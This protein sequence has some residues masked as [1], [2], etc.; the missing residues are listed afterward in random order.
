MC[1]SDLT[2]IPVEKWAEDGI[3][4]RRIRIYPSRQQRKIL[5]EWIHTTRYVYNRCVH[6]L[7][8]VK[9]SKWDHSYLKSLFITHKS[10][11]GQINQNL[12]EWEL[13]T[14][15]HVRDG[16]VR[17]LLKGYTNAV[18]RCKKGSIARFN[19]RYRKRNKN[20]AIVIPKNSVR[21]ENGK[22]RMFPRSLPELIRTSRDKSVQNLVIDHDC[23]LQYK[24]GKWYLAVPIKVKYSPETGLKKGVASLDPGVRTF[25]TIYNEEEVTQ[26]CHNRELLRRIQCK[27]DKFRSLRA[28]KVIGSSHYKR[29]TRRLYERLYNLTDELHYKTISHLCENYRLILI[30]IFESQE[31]GMR[32]KNRYMNREMFQLQH[33]K[34]RQRLSERCGVEKYTSM[35]V[36]SE[37]H[38]SKTCSSCGNYNSNL[39]A[40]S[41]YSCVKCDLSCDRDVNASK[42]V[43]IRY[44]RYHSLSNK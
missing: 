36:V 14:P 35:V 40:S 32:S 30:P 7:K 19:M 34:F 25:Q 28:K 3:R 9:D 6:H 4:T 23:R 15:K 20:S 16:A 11:S 44:C 5:R 2:S 42:N 8:T 18:K 29:R 38:T 31:M 37:A 26:V 17:D 10:R 12:T 41:K 39:G 22:L 27:L 33:Y 21:M 13:K 43:L 24:F 1:S